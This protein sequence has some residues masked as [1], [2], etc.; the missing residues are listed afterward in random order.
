MMRRRTT[1]RTAPR[2]YRPSTPRPQVSPRLRPGADR[3]DP[4]SPRRVPTRAAARPARRRNVHFSSSASGNSALQDHA[5]ERRERLAPP[6]SR[7]NFA[8]IARPTTCSTSLQ[9]QPDADG[10]LQLRAADPD[11]VV[12]AEPGHLRFRDHLYLAR[13]G[14]SCSRRAPTTTRARF[15]SSSITPCKPQ[16]ERQQAA[17]LPSR[18]APQAHRSPRRRRRR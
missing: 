17:R 11:G 1:A 9:G 4:R 5:A 14:P 7:W 3:R 10:V 18:Q 13:P 16:Q 2:S 12:G 6:P 8:P 15:R